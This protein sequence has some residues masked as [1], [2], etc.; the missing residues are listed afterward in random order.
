MSVTLNSLPGV[1]TL[2]LYSGGRMASYL[3]TFANAS[4]FA[5]LGPDTLAGT[6]SWDSDPAHP[7]V[8]TVTQT[9]SSYPPVPYYLT[10]FLVGGAMGG[11]ISTQPDP[12]VPPDLGLWSGQ[13][14]DD[15]DARGEDPR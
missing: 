6:W 8:L 14:Q 13:K 9:S 15:L 10:G 7:V 12:T 3:T 5:A 1:W 11:G 4:Q 2:W